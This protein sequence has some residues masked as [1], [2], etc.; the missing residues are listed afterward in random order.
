M[1]RRGPDYPDQFLRLIPTSG[2]SVFSRRRVVW[3]L[4]SS[5]GFESF[6]PLGRLSVVSRSGPSV[7]GWRLVV[8]VPWLSG[9]GKAFETVSVLWEMNRWRPI[10]IR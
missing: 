3:A 1:G 5:V 4:R 6:G 9:G 7:F 2:P 8:R 10:G